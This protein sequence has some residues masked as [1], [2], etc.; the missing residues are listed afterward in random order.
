VTNLLK[1]FPKPLLDDIVRGRCLPIIG[2]G[3]SKNANCPP[4][5][6][7]LLWDELGEAIATELEG[8]KFRTALDAISTY[9]HTHKRGKL[10][11]RLTDLL[12]INEAT[13]GA[14]HSAFCKLPFDVVCTTNFD[15][16]LEAAYSG[17]RYCRPILDEDQLSVSAPKNAVT[18]LKLHGDVH[19]PNR[20]VATEEDYD[21]FLVNN[22]LLATYLA[23]LLIGRT[24]LFI[25]YSFD[26]PDFRQIWQVLGDRLGRLR[27]PAFALV[28]EATHYDIARYERR[29]VSVI[30]LPGR[31]A[32]LGATLTDLFEQ[33]SKLWS[34]Q[35]V[36]ESTATSEEIGAE[37]S[38]PTGAASRLCLFAV[39]SSA[40]ALYREHA[41]PVAEKH[42]FAP[43]TADE[44][45]S[46]GENLFAKVAALIEK[47][48][49][50][51][52]DVTSPNALIEAGYAL[53]TRPGDRRVVLVSDAIASVP[54]D[55]AQHQF[56]IRPSVAGGNFDT[57]IQSL[58]RTLAALAA[59]LGVKLLDEP[60][61]L[62]RAR[63][64]KAAIIAAIS[65]L[66]A[67]LRR[68]LGQTSGRVGLVQ[69]VRA[70]DDRGLLLPAE[71]AVIGDS[72]KLRNGLLHEGLPATLQQAKRSLGQI[73]PVVQ[74]LRATE[75]RV[76]TP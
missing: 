31:M 28:A 13:P 76:I 29:G 25:G 61:R 1:H 19:H 63:E 54:A 56:L 10:T 16:L 30:E 45:I 46:P 42:G 73:L 58:D 22:P 75:P 27:R 32:D 70:A 6:K 52:V 66:E 34:G 47:A 39:P 55:L 69:L 8:Y 40:Q 48:D 4:G 67:E 49:V 5:K 24:P 26:D 38:L 65:A 64:Y 23:S 17:T 3:F 44:V 18:L 59:Q 51:V 41:F 15:F 35:L 7:P 71:L 50:V 57:F 53:A 60:E 2:A 11:E 33:L 43:A 37:L 20:M 68:V 21:A 74:R 12:L 36:A 62:L 72:T 14:A 9:A